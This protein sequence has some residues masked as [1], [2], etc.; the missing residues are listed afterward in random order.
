MCAC[1]SC[2]QAAYSCRHQCLCLIRHRSYCPLGCFPCSALAGVANTVLRFVCPHSCALQGTAKTA[3]RPL[4]LHYRNLVGGDDSLYDALLA[5]G[6][7]DVAYNLAM[8]AATE[9]KWRNR[10]IKYLFLFSL[11][12]YLTPA[13][14]AIERAV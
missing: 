14:A 9:N 3:V 2:G 12:W 11:I 8:R 7:A 1:A 6:E 4:T 10:G 13:R 5:S